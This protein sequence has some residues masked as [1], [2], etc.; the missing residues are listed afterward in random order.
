MFR[1]FI[2]WF[3]PAP[4]QPRLPAEEIAR[5]YPRL[6]GQVFEAAFVA[7]ATFYVVRNNFAPVSKEIGAALHYDKTLIGTILASTAFAYGVGKFVMGYLADQSDSRKYMAVG[8]TLTAICNFLFGATLDYHQQLLL[9]TLNGFVQG[10]GYGPCARGLAHWYSARER[11]TVF[12]VWNTSHCI[13]G[14]AAGFVAAFC[15]AHWGWRSAFYVPGAI[16]ALGAVYLFWRM[17]DTPQSEGLPPVEEF[18]NDRPADGRQEPEHELSFREM[19]L[20][21]ILPN[22]LLWVLAFAN[23]FVYIARYAMVDWGPTYLKEVKG[24]S[25]ISGGIS[26][27]VIELSGAAGMIIMGLISDRIGGRRARLSALAMIPLPLAF[28]GLIVSGSL[29]LTPG[30]IQSPGKLATELQ[31]GISSV[32]HYVWAQI[33]DPLR[34][35]I[36]KPGLSVEAEQYA[37]ANGLNAVLTNANFYVPAVFTGMP[38]RAKTQKWLPQKLTGA[39]SDYRNRL[40]LEDAFPEIR[41]CLFTPAHLLWMNLLLFG[42]I[43]F[44]VYTPVTFS[45]VVALDLTSK[46]A[47]AT[48]AGFVGMFGY[49]GGRV[50]QGLGL[51]WLAQNYGWDAALYAVIGCIVIGFILLAFLWN[52]RPK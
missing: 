45:G 30:D 3:K 16:A 6:R 29:L 32:D 17:R 11:G 52:V 19:F 15:A 41:Q 21:H 34:T 26:T 24:A 25:L 36:R 40:L 42:L 4:P 48:A 51:G 10:M 22:K 28:F 38:L 47:Q 20:H 33:P 27:V 5:R 1:K 2:Q 37:L 49:V 13:G 44:F 14:G 12:G 46:K 35:E 43:G 9:W 31:T 23:I 7:Y 50:I 8:M 18:K 39:R